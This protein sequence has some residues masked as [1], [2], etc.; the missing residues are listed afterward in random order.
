[1]RWPGSSCSFF[2]PPLAAAFQWLSVS[3]DLCIKDSSYKQIRIVVEF[4]STC[5][6]LHVVVSHIE[7]VKIIILKFSDRILMW[8]IPLL[9]LIVV[10]LHQIHYVCILEYNLVMLFK[11]FVLTVRISSTFASF[12]L[13]SDSHLSAR[14]ATL[15]RGIQISL[16]ILS[17]FHIIFPPLLVLLPKNRPQSQFSH[18]NSK[19][20]LEGLFLIDWGHSMVQSSF[21]QL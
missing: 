11:A 21:L 5:I 10:T 20:V 16:R 18:P 15:K 2:P 9:S 3:V 13:F 6:Y 7:H 4:L 1:M 17:S 19:K 12:G 8:K 14:D